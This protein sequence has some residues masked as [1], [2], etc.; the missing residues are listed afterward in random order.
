MEVVFGSNSKLVADTVC[1]VMKDECVSDTLEP[2]PLGRLYTSN[3]LDLDNKRRLIPL[4]VYI[5]YSLEHQSRCLQKVQSQHLEP[6]NVHYILYDFPKAS[7]WPSVLANG[8]GYVLVGV[9]DE[10]KTWVGRVV[11]ILVGVFMQTRGLVLNMQGVLKMINKGVYAA[12]FILQPQSWYFIH[13]P[14]IVKALKKTAASLPDSNVNDFEAVSCK[15][16]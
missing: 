5:D 6:R 15:D 7:E 14:T 11:A 4:F 1:R 12:K 13:V 2:S 16:C 10:H 3:T 8:H 9:D